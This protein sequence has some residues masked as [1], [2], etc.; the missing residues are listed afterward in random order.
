MKAYE[1]QAKNP[2]KTRVDIYAVPADPTTHTHTVQLRLTSVIGDLA[3]KII[4]EIK[5]DKGV[6]TGKSLSAIARIQEALGKQYA[7]RE[8]DSNLYLLARSYAK[9]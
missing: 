1:E 5:D 8:K 4:K 3:D 7:S 2:N 9:K 6:V